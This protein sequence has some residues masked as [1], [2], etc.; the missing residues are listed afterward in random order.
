MGEVTQ[1][2]LICESEGS[3]A[4]TFEAT[5]VALGA[6]SGRTNGGNIAQRYFA[7]TNRRDNPRAL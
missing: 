3:I 6:R 4:S 1:G 7:C 5:S 2:D